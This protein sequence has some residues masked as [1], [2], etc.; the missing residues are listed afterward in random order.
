MKKFTVTA[1]EENQRVDKFVMKILS[2]ATK[3]FI[4]KMIRKKNIKLNGQKF[5]G[6]EILKTGDEITIFFS[7]ETFD[8]FTEE[9]GSP[10]QVKTT[11]GVIYEDEHLLVCDK[12]VGLLSQPDGEG[13]NLVDQVVYYLSGQQSQK[14][15]GFKPGVCNRLDRN[16][17]GIVIAGKNI[18]ALQAINKAIADHQVDKSYL[19]IV[20]GT[21]SGENE[22]EGY[23]VKNEAENLVSISQK[24]PGDYIKT[25]YKPILAN[26]DY[27][28]LEVRIITGKSHQIRA[29]LESISH[30]VIGD[31]KYGDP[32]TN[33]Y[34]LQ[35]FGLK[36]QL[37]HAY[38]FQFH[39][40]EQPF[41][42]LNE[43]VFMAPLPKQF[44]NILSTLFPEASNEY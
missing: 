44:K 21:I 41:D 16:T 12:P 19:T 11:F 14:M 6:H 10:V 36:Y 8:T 1:T 28:L 35:K 18:K 9:T 40:L 2:K 43:K 4:Y 20:K 13:D 33:R 38:Q 15:V 24:P 26:P 22:I 25:I 39:Q 31:G 42:Y 29:H 23:L 34:F 5:D 32:Q 37:L 7:D 27:T 3:S 17:S 30:P